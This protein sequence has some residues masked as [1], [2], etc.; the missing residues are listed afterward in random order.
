MPRFLPLLAFS[1]LSL[2]L[3]GCGK[4][5]PTQYYAFEGADCSLQCDT[6]PKRTLRVARVGI[7]QYLERE[8]LVQ[9]KP[10]CVALTVD[11]LHVWAEPLA[12]GIRRLLA[13]GLTEPLLANG[14]TVLP[15]GSESRGT[16][17]L[18]LDI[19]HLDG[20]KEGEA[21]LSAQ[22][23]LLE[24]ESN[25]VLDDGLFSARKHVPEANNASLVATW[26]QLITEA[27]EHIAGRINQKFSKS[28][29]LQR[30]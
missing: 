1:F 8:A 12:D 3:F 20:V 18:L 7:P 21:T 15:L 2:T 28:R 24:S 6:L 14:L 22:W 27:T 9:R 11:S 26:A 16:Y 19:L 30:R 17:T 25:L 4:S 29:S 23:S 10:G 13:N 5:L